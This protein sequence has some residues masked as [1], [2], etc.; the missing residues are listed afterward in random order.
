MTAPF[1][2]TIIVSNT[3]EEQT[4]KQ[5][6][7]ITKVRS[8]GKQGGTLVCHLLQDL[9]V[10]GSNLNKE[11]S[12]QTRLLSIQM[13]KYKKGTASLS[14]KPWH[15]RLEL[16][17]PLHHHS[18]LNCFPRSLMTKGICSLGVVYFD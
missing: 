17:L 5:T 11:E 13:D 15:Q 4:N 14:V 9:K 1:D 7:K 10:L 16:A 6:E 8:G 3:M 18:F 2:T 12:I